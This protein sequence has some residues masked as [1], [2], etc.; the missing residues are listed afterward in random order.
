MN[1]TEKE[2][3]ICATSKRWWNVNIHERTKK[4][5]REKLRRWT[6]GPGADVKALL[7]RGTGQ[8]MRDIYRD[9]LQ[10]IRGADV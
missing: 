1:A 5:G 9:Y 4:V 8:S 2:I 3:K 7:N 6:S 10:T